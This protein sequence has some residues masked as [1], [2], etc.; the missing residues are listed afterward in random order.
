[1]K[2]CREFEALIDRAQAGEAS[3]ED[4]EALLDHFE[5][6]Q[7]C[8]DVFEAVG[9]LRNSDI[10]PEPTEEELLSMRRAVIREIR[11]ERTSRKPGRR[12]AIP[13]FFTRP[14]PVAVLALGMLALGFLLGGR[15]AGVERNNGRLQISDSPDRFMSTMKTVAQSHGAYEDI[16]NSPFTYTNVRVTEADAGMVNLSF[17]VS[18]HLDLSLRRNDTL[19]T[20][21]LVQSLIEPSGI[22]TRLT[23]IS[24][25]DRL[26]D[27]KIKKSLIVAMLH[28]ENLAVRMTAQSKL[29]D[30][31]RDPEI[32]ES[33]LSVLE[34]E[35]SVQMRLVAIDYLTS[36]NIQPE[37]LERAIA[38]GKSEGTE[39][40][41][42][43]ASQ[44]LK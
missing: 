44:Y 6:C 30:R 36:S 5:S 38:A 15:T 33:L 41:L 25:A 18:R 19:V 29:V 42:V 23:A 7:D 17:D 35:P 20:E 8:S 32:I 22:D 9:R 10:H 11:L 1:M 27:P 40:V 13:S 14:V 31:A 39:A 37:R 21:V 4:R 24:I 34:R 2:E 16:V 43:R 3:E 12:F 28:D 26:P